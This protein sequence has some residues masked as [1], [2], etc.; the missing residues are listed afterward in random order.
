MKASLL[1]M[2]KISNFNVAAAYETLL[3]VGKVRRTK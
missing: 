3:I 1:Y 2:G